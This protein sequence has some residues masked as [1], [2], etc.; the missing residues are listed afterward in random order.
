LAQNIRSISDLQALLLTPSD[1]EVCLIDEIHE[2]HPIAQTTLYRAME[3][4]QIFL[5]TKRGRK[6]RPIK[7]AN[8]TIIGATTDPQKLLEPLRDRFKLVLEFEFYSEQELETLLRTRTQQMG[9]HVQDAVFQMI[10]QRGKG[11]PRIALRL[12]DSTRMVAYSENAEVITT[13][14]FHRAC[15]LEGIDHIGLTTSE[16]K[17][18]KILYENDGKARLNVIASRLGLN[19][20]I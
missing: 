14:H 11:T 3:N 7:I 9:M 20:Q 8:F 4:Q 19:P 15:Q 10:A 16:I 5:E 2:L 6:S 18:L 13:N 12:L 1:R 17:Y